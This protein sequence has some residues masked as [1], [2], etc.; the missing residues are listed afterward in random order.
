VGQWGWDFLK[1]L[2]GDELHLRLSFS[3]QFISD[4][5]LGVILSLH[6]VGLRILLAHIK[7][8]PRRLESTVRYL[9]G[10]TF[11]IYL[12]HQ[13]LLWFYSAVFAFVEEGLSRYLVVVPSTILSIFVLAAFTEQKKNVWKGWVEQLL[14]LVEQAGSKFREAMAR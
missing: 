5:Y 11:S 2:L 13:P 1:R 4:Y 3:R 12:F 14:A 8:V 10:A 9:A 7:T 6:F